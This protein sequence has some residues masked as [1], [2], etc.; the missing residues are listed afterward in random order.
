MKELIFITSSSQKLAHAKHLSKDFAIRISKQKNYGIGYKEPRIEDREELIR[1]SVEDAIQRFKKN[2]PN[3]DNKFFFIEDTSV[4][5]TALS[6]EK[7]YPGVDIK[8]WMK[9][10]DFSTIDKMLKENGNN[11]Q[12]IVRS[13]VVLVFPKTMQGKLEGKYKRF[14]SLVI[15]K[16]SEQDLLVKTQ[17]LYPWL[18]QKTFNKWFIPEGC[19]KPLTLLDINEADK[20]DFRAYAFKQMFEYLHSNKIIETNFE[21]N[22]KKSEQSK[23]FAPFLFIICGPTCAGKTTIATHLVDKY[24]Y[25]HLEA[26]DFMHLS[27][28]ESHG[29]KPDI[30]IADFAADALKKNPA[31]VTDRII[32][33]IEKIKSVPIVITGFRDPKEIYTFQKLYTGDFFIQKIYVDADIKL[34]FERNIIR[35]RSDGQKTYDDFLQKDLQQFGMGLD[36]IRD[37]SERS[38]IENNQSKEDFYSNFETLFHEQ[39]EATKNNLNL[40]VPKEILSKKLQNAIIS[41]L[42]KQSDQTVYYTTTEIAHLIN[43]DSKYLSAQK[44]KNNVSRYFN[45]NFHPYFDIDIN[46][47]GRAIYKLSQTGLAYSKFIAERG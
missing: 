10:N 29:L 24:R 41:T 16:I 19:N 7:E 13:D 43:A 37:Q 2:T 5:I 25:Y 22:F 45:Q 30:S 21:A 38:I 33:N 35:N 23:L 46:E 12:A 11:R 31:V 27:F 14:T 42:A 3:S 15:G 17:P 34:R 47:A 1:E 20:H 26:S 6:K 9:E 8:Y 4:I 40:L 39:L 44:S 18:S 36:L 32:S 28:H